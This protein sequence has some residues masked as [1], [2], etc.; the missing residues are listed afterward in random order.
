[1]TVR[2]AVAS[3]DVEGEEASLC[4]TN[5]A[6]R[7]G[8]VLSRVEATVVHDGSGWRATNV[9]LYPNDGTVGVPQGDVANGGRGPND[10]ETLVLTRLL[11][12]RCT[13]NNRRATGSGH[14][15]LA[16]ERQELL[17]ASVDVVM[18]VK[19][20]G[21][22]P[23]TTR[24]RVVSPPFIVRHDYPHKRR[25]TARD[26]VKPDTTSEQV[27]AAVTSA[28]SSP[29]APPPDGAWKSSAG[30]LTT[31][32]RVSIGTESSP[33][34]LTVHGNA[35]VTGSVRTLSDARLK[36]D[37]V[38]VSG[39]DALRVVRALR[40]YTYSWHDAVPNQPAGQRQVGLIAQEVQRVMPEAVREVQ[41]G[42]PG[43][44][45]TILSVDYQ[46]VAAANVGAVRELSRIVEAHGNAIYELQ[47]VVER[48][49]NQQ[50]AVFSMPEPETSKGKEA[51]SGPPFA[52]REFFAWRRPCWIW[53]LFGLI[54]LVSGLAL[55]WTAQTDAIGDVTT[56]PDQPQRGGGVDDGFVLVPVDVENMEESDSDD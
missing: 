42:L 52:S 23:P 18:Q 48:P 12:S 19:G 27:P 43:G 21:S 33:E 55:L 14:R 56:M 46:Q 7:P 9:M 50:L 40:L 53:P 39:V 10:V 31:L 20:M 35:L 25:R 32:D 15:P 3:S 54:F 16:D 51:T 34:A 41:S 4:L 26:D 28:P 45:A 6:R 44:P 5:R 17:T 24:V 49:K 36:V 38:H 2:L 11:F 47:C 13:A 29:A 37:I 22:S 1:M 8:D 30:A